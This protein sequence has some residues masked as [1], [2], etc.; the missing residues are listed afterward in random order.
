MHRGAV[1][2]YDKVSGRE[3]LTDYGNPGQ[4]VVLDGLFLAAKKRTLDAV[5]LIKPNYLIG[6]WDFYDLHYT[7]TA[8]QMGLKNKVI[9]MNI[10]HNSVGELAGRDSWHQNRMAFISQFDLPCRV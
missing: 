8:H 10:L 4:V 6:D 2:H 5:G 7:M 1:H 9:P 3:Y